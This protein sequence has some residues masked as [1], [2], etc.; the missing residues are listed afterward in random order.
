MMR[1][2]LTTCFLYCWTLSAG[3][4]MF[5]PEVIDLVGDP[6]TEQITYNFDIENKGTEEVTYFWK[7]VKDEGFPQEWFTQICDSRLCYAENEDQSNPELANTIAGEAKD[8][9][10]IYLFSEGV[11]ASTSVT[12]EI[13]SDPELTNLLLSIPSENF[14]VTSS[15]STFN[16]SVDPELALFPNP[17]SDFF[18]IRNDGGVKEIALYHISGKKIKTYSHT[19]GK[20]HSIES[21]RKGLYLVRLFD[22]NGNVMKSLRVSKR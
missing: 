1:Y 20:Q 11:E 9:L 4:L 6:E 17:T 15:T 21:L 16:L 7:F 8:D 10:Q 3:Q 22:G 13:Y 2:L 12:L 5:D 14:T 19:P 18:Q